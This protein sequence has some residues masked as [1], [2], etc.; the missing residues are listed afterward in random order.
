MATRL[1]VGN[2]SF[3]TSEDALKELFSKHGEVVSC[4]LITDKFSGRSR[5]FGFI[6]M[7]AQD[8]ANAAIAQL[9][10]IDFDG[11]KLTVNEARPREERAPRS[12]RGPRFGGGGGGRDRGDHGGGG[13]DF[14]GGRR[15]SR[16]E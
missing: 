4:N 14:R 6:E 2:L 3:S 7:A 10:G 13:R 5:G 1:Y 9:N 15:N 8:A 11:R 16:D 12:D